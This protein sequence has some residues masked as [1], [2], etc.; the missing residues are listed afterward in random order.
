MFV[1]SMRF[2]R[3]KMN[4]KFSKPTVK[5][6]R[7]Y[8]VENLPTSKSQKHFLWKLFHSSNGTAVSDIATL[9]YFQC[10]F[11]AGPS[12]PIRKCSSYLLFYASKNI[13]SYL[14]RVILLNHILKRVFLL[15]QES[16]ILVLEG[17]CPSSFLVCP[18]NYLIGST[19]CLLET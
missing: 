16:P 2:L 5:R 1:F 10:K 12:L 4:V 14:S 9:L 8:R 15:K 17:W 11:Y 18:L 19:K 7:V 13:S 3:I 6:T